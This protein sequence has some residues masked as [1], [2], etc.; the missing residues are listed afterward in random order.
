MRKPRGRRMESGL[1]LAII[2]RFIW[3]EFAISFS[4]QK[5]GHATRRNENAIKGRKSKA[6][7]SGKVSED[8]ELAEDLSYSNFSDYI[9]VGSA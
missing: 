6:R 1:Q 2:L 8:A 4:L 5:N 7:A 3:W 9:V